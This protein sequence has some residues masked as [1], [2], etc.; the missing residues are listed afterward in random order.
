MANAPLPLPVPPGLA[1]GVPHRTKGSLA[2][3]GRKLLL[4]LPLGLSGLVQGGAPSVPV[5]PANPEPAYFKTGVLTLEDRVWAQTQIERVFYNHLA[6][7]R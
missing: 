5:L 1:N 7:P 3:L 4:S 6:Q 2:R